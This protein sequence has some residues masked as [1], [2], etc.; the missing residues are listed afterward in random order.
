[1]SRGRAVSSPTD[2]T[3]GR[4]PHT[5]SRV[6]TGLAKENEMRQAGTSRSNPSARRFRGSPAHRILA[7]IPTPGP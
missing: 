2:S 6:E 3:T 1:M 4:I 5:R 7:A